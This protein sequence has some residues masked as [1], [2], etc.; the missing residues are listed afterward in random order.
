MG[1]TS[2]QCVEREIGEELNLSVTALDLID[3]YL[4]E[5]IPEKFVLIVT[6]GCRLDSPFI[7]RISDEH[8]RIGTFIPDRLP[9]NL[10]SGYRSSIETW[11]SRTTKAEL[12]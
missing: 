2:E 10:P 1:E 6:Y 11:C 5:V 3:T 9:S 12:A 7:P 8:K 4:F